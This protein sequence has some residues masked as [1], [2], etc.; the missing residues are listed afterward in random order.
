M[1][2]KVDPKIARLNAPRRA[3]A[4]ASR[5]A[6]RRAASTQNLLFRFARSMFVSFQ[7]IRNVR[8]RH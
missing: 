1:R 6:R 2:P 5:S 3:A 8:F 4:V 7:E